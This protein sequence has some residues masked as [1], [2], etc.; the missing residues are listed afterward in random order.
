MT[1]GRINQVTFIFRDGIFTKNGFGD[2]GLGYRVGG[3]LV[4]GGIVGVLQEVAVCV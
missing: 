2:C 4:V 3:G 1:T